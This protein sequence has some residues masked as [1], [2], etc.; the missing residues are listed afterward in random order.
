MTKHTPLPNLLRPVAIVLTLVMMALSFGAVG[1]A[2]ATQTPPATVPAT[3]AGEQLAWTLDV[4]A[5]G[6][7][8]L[9]EAEVEHRFAPSLLAVL[10]ATQAVSGTRDLA[11]YGPFTLLG[12]A[13]PPAATQLVALL[14]TGTG[15]RL[16]A[17]I[18]VEP[19]QPHRIVTLNMQP[20]AE[21][22]EPT[23]AVDRLGGLIDIGGRSLF[24]SC[25]EPAG[26][27]DAEGPT[28]VLEA[29]H[30][31]NSTVWLAVQATVGKTTRVCAYDRANAT[32]GASDPAPTP[33]DGADVV[34]DLH[35]LLTTASVPGPYVL[36]G[37]S[38]GGL[39]VRLYAGAHPTE[40]AGLV[41]V[42][43]SH[44]DQEERIR[45]L[46]GP[47]LWAQLESARSA[48]ADPEGFDLARIGKEVRRARTADPLRSMPLVVLTH[49]QSDAAQL[50]TGWPIEAEERLWRELQTDLA[51]LIPTGR[52]VV[53][54]E[55]GHFIQID[56][57]ELVVEAIDEVLRTADTEQ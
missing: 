31:N 11:A 53:A 32:G 21:S 43:A 9:T 17:E 46:V 47:E 34:A 5:S 14:T 15:Q 25:T 40:V 22:L 36:V 2:V 38:L 33:R 23:D 50:P 51:S 30:G 41:L 18:T 52:L 49:G 19:D 39:F 56:Q 29:G 27:T 48:T 54:E 10:P 6:G 4:L 13:R 44:E 16:T 1:S 45:D 55:S 26:V 20:A 37:H 24:L 3:P 12:F 28:V 35:A 7:T 8:T 57:P 42:D